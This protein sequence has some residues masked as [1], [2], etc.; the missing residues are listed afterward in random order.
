MRIALLL[1]I[2]VLLSACAINREVTIIQ[3]VKT[4]EIAQK[5]QSKPIERGEIMKLT[6]K[7]FNQGEMIPKEFTCQGDDSSPHLAWEDAPA[8]TKSFA[9]IVDDPDAPGGTWVH[10]LVKDI[11]PN[12]KE[13]QQNNVPGNQVQNDFGKQDY[14]GPCPP[15]GTHRYFFR[16][17]ALDVGNLEANNKQDFYKEAEAHAIAKAELMGNYQKS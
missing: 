17:Y 11:P 7:S 3:E 13:I 10:W 6:S 14:G 9:L 1:L 12:V 2:L 4:D 16:L 5:E 15:S 8:E